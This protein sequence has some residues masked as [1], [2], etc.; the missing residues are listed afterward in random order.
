M[1]RPASISPVQKGET[2][3]SCFGAFPSA[4]FRSRHLDPQ[5]T[6]L[7][8]GLAKHLEGYQAGIGR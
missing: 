4:W 7:R 5:A 1:G 3:A 2:E 8:R 6:T